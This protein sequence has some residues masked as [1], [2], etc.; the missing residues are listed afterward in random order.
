MHLA[1]SIRVCVCLA[2]RKASGYLC[3][4]EWREEAGS[5][6]GGWC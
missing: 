6:V 1:Q 5:W 3:V 2:A 4:C